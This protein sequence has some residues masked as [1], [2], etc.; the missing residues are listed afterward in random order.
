M[1]GEAVRKWIESVN[2]GQVLTISLAVG[3]LVMIIIQLTKSNARNNKAIQQPEGA[4]SVMPDENTARV[5]YDKMTPEVK[6]K[7]D[8]I[9]EQ[10]KDAASTHLGF[11]PNI[12][13]DQIINELLK[14]TNFNFSPN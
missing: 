5:I 11:R 14:K 9:I 6:R 13:R 1:N 3:Q 4:T 10:A 2:W 12:S 7:I 8:E